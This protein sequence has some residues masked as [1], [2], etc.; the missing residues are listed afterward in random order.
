MTPL[1]FGSA[2]PA[3]LPATPQTSSPLE[4]IVLMVGDALL[5]AGAAVLPPPALF[6]AI[7]GPASV[8]AARPAAR[9]VVRSIELASP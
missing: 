2:R 9:S 8:A 1:L 3:T 4:R 6:C 7:A 5:P